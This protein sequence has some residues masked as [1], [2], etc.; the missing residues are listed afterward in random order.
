MGYRDGTRID[1]MHNVQSSARM[2]TQQLKCSLKRKCSPNRRN[3]HSRVK[4]IQPPILKN[5]HPLVEM[6][7]EE[8]NPSKHPF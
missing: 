6:F 7:T 8:L 4:P 1:Q 2:F 5:V 3:V